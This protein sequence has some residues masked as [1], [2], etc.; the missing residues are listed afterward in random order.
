MSGQAFEGAIYMNIEEF[1][2]DKTENG[3]GKI[4]N[5]PIEK[6]IEIITTISKTTLFLGLCCSIF[7][8]MSFLIK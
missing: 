8:I 5:F 4:D 6:H 2:S 3:F 7:V 1:T